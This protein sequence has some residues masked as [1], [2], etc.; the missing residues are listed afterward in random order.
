MRSIIVHQ[1]SLDIA[2]DRSV[3][4]SN[5]S[6][7]NL[8]RRFSI[9]CIGL[10]MLLLISLPTSVLGERRGSS[11][12]SAPATL[13]S[14]VPGGTLPGS[15]VTFA[16]TAGTGVEAYD[17][18]LNTAPGNPE[19]PTAT[20]FF[21]SGT[22][23]NRA[24]TLSS[25]PMKGV[26]IYA[27]LGSE[28]NGSWQWITYTLKEASPAAT[29]STPAAALTALTCATSSLAAAGTDSCNVTL[30]A[31]ATGSGLTVGLA[32]NNSAATVPASVTVPAGSTSAG[33]TATASAVTSSQSVTLTASAG[34]VKE[35]FALQLGSSVSTLSV[36]STSI[37]FGDVS[38]GSPATQSVT[39]SATGSASVTVSAASVTGTGFSVSGATFPLTL[40]PNQTATLN[41]QFDPTA[42]GSSTGQL[43]IKS[44]SSTNATDVVSLSG[45]GE[46][47]SYQVELT[48]SAPTSTPQPVAG[49][50][51]YRSPSGGT[52]YQ[53]LNS[54]ALTQTT[55]ADT[56]AQAGQTY[57]YIVE[58][59]DASGTTSGPSNMA[60]I[61][62][63]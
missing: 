51:V 32:S 17:L 42:A 28:I 61:V 9:P 62:I 12:T 40:T 45:S 33:F 2:T 46:S 57:D 11:S 29:A 6:Q 36:N 22:D 43:T 16:W 56:T 44:N 48:W 20:R 27:I 53:Q 13:T 21:D 4:N 50:N 49:Y 14:P 1:P 7:P 18:H 41:V 52:S 58:S 24:Y 25:I 59:V 55:F 63:P 10:L 34:S 37:A 26:T 54:A 23:S 8:S 3:S 39:L 19:D 60:S 5:P 31:A 47:T 35:S 38:L 30:S 15:T